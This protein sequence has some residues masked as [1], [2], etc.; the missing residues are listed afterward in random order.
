MKQADDNKTRELG[1]EPRR[2]RP[3]KYANDAEK[4][5]AYRE[6]KGLGILTIQLPKELL[7][8]FTAWV[9]KRAQDTD[10]SVSKVIENVI[11]KQVLRKR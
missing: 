9:Q 6:R 8:R 11:E 3:R 10:T 5:K 2:G 1:L 4:Q 7:E